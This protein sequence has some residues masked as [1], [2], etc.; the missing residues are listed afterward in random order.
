MK[1]GKSRS[2]FQFLILIKTA[3]GRV[4]RWWRNRTRRKLYPWQIHQNVIWILSNVHKTSECWWRTPGCQKGSP[5][6]SKKEGFDYQLDY[7]PPFWCCLFSSRSLLSLSSLSL[8]YILCESLWVL[9]CGEH[10]EIWL[11]ARLLPPFWHALFSY[12]SSLS[13][14]SPSLLY[15]TM[16]VSLGVPVCGEWLHQ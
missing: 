12:C 3:Q 7:S 6:S 1:S 11:L 15:I 9:G 2:S 14:S 4:P 16:W 13:P 8:L 5:I 10:L